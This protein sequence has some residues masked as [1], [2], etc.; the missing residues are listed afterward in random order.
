MKKI[1]SIGLSLVMCVAFVGIAAAQDMNCT[2]STKISQS[3]NLCTITP[4]QK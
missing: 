4:I 3:M 1:L 2:I